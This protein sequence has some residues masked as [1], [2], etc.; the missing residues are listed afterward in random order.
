[1]GYQRDKIGR[2]GEVWMK[3]IEQMWAAEW[4]ARIGVDTNSGR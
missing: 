1:V 4:V 2:G 3:V